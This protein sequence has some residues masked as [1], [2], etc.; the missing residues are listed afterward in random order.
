MRRDCNRRR[1]SSFAWIPPVVLQP[2][3]SIRSSSS[4]LPFIFFHSSFSPTI[5]RS[6][7]RWLSFVQSKDNQNIGI[8][9]FLF[10]FIVVIVVFLFFI[11]LLFFI[12]FLFFFIFLFIVVIIAVFLFIVVI[13][14]VFLFIVVIIFNLW[15]ILFHSMSRS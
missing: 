14:A 12:I 3:R 13:I 15:R 5:L 4:T 6:I 10:I 1:I 7:M 8:F 2:E 11:I 9:L